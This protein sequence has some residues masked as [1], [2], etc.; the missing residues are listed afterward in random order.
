MSFFWCVKWMSGR[1]PAIIIRLDFP[2]ASLQRILSLIRPVLDWQI[3]FWV[4]TIDHLFTAHALIIVICNQYGAFF[5]FTSQEFPSSN[6]YAW[7]SFKLNLWSCC[8]QRGR[9]VIPHSSITEL[10]IYK[11]ANVA[12]RCYPGPACTPISRVHLWVWVHLGHNF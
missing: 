9:G 2:L 7:P 11:I 10:T 3:L 1:L 12:W 5:A 4:Q 6:K 8:C